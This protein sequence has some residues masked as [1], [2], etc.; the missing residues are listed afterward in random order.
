MKK[1][2]VFFALSRAAVLFV[3]M[4]VAV[5]MSSCDFLS[6]LFGGGDDFE[7][8]NSIAAAVP[9]ERD[10]SYTAYIGEDDADFF[11]FTTAHGSATFDEVEISVT[12]VGDD[13][14]ILVAIYNPDGEL[15]G[16]KTSTTGGADL[17]YTVR[18]LNSDGTYTVRFSGSWGSGYEVDGIGDYETQGVYTFKVSNLDANDEFA[19]NHSINDAAPIVT[20]TS[21]NGVLVSKYEADYVSFTPSTDTMQLV[22]TGVGDDLIIGV[23]LYAPDKSLMGTNSSTTAGANLTTNL[24]SMNT[25]E[26]YYIRFSGTWGS[27][28]DVGGIGDFYSRG[29]YTF[30]L[31][32]N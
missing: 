26:T 25:S 7:P 23:A 5:T 18:N 29:P 1:S 14:K 22:I 32:D 24:L 20:G 15:Y 11:S 28:W 8:N 12:N 10:M 9:I 6:G 16:S 2:M 4:G 19:G 13:L 3:V 21:Y 31:N 27:G 30:V 17:T